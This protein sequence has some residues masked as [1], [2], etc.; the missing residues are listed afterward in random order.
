MSRFVEVHI[1]NASRQLK[2]IAE[3]GFKGIKKPAANDLNECVKYAAKMANKHQCDY[4]VVALYN[5]YLISPRADAKNA[6]D[7]FGNGFR[8]TKDAEVFKMKVK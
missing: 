8:V 4:W 6:Y 3:G 5:R 1:E 2:E 7:D